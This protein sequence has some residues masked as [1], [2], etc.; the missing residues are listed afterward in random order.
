MFK[1]IVNIVE[2]LALVAALGF[3]IALFRG[4]S[5]TGSSS[6]G[7]RTGAEIYSASCSACHGDDGQGGVGPQL[8]DGAVVEA[9]PD[10]ADE[11]EVVTNGRAAMPSF[12]SSL[13]EDEIQAVVDYTRT[14]LG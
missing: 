5:D 7:P 10:A 11:V 3:G 14:S 1:K 9:F 12:A 6:S 13:S 4:G 8:A 2:V